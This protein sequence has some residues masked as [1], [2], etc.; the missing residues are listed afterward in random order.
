MEFDHWIF[1]STD[2]V[3]EGRSCNKPRDKGPVRGEKSTVAI[4]FRQLSVNF[5]AFLCNNSIPFI[6]SFVFVANAV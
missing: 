6:L 4:S 3:E 2:S 1:H 5:K